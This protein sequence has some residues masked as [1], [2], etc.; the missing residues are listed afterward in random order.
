MEDFCRN[1]V[2]VIA[3]RHSCLSLQPVIRGR[4][5]PELKIC[6]ST[7]L[8]AFSL[9]FWVATGSYQL[10]LL[11]FSFF[12]VLFLMKLVSF[13]ASNTDLEM[14][15]LTVKFKYLGHNVRTALKY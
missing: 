11:V 4:E 8:F 13:K 7:C 3:L 5:V 2:L 6:S 14:E 15:V 9:L 10:V 1:F 12:F